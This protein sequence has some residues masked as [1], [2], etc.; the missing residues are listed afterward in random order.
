MLLFVELS[1]PPHPFLRINAE[2]VGD[3]IDV[4]EIAD[5]FDRVEHVFVGQSGGAESFD[6]LFAD[7]PGLSRQYICKLAERALAFIQARVAIIFF[8]LR[9]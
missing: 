1:L 2:S 8:E 7:A 6:F 9:D 5:N 4:V 3:A